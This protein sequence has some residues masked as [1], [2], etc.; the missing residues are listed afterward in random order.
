[1]CVH[2]MPEDGTKT[3]QIFIGEPAQPSATLED[4]AVLSM[5]RH[6]AIS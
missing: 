4:G 2:V 5:C 3:K 6:A 1:M